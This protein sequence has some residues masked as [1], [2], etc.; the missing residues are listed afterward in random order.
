MCANLK[1][2][3][4]LQSGINWRFAELTFVSRLYRSCSV[5]GTYVRRCGCR[6]T[7]ALEIRVGGGEKSYV[8]SAP[9]LHQVAPMDQNTDHPGKRA[10][11]SSPQINRPG[12][13]DVSLV[14]L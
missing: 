12:I 10:G 9:R 11:N 7:R 8:K 3:A 1:F 4:L 2:A 6:P 5:I 14:T 13:G